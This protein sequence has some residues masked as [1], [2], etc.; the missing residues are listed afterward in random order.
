MLRGL[1][2]QIGLCRDAGVNL[3][4]TADVYSNGVS[5]EIVGEALGKD[6]DEVLVATKVRFPMGAGPN[7]AGLYAPSHREGGRGQPAPPAHRPYRPVPGARV[8]WPDPLEET[9]SAFDS[10]VR[11]GKVRYIGASNYSAW[12][13]MKAL[14]VSK[15]YGFARFVSQQIYYSLQAGCGIGIGA[16]LDRPGTRHPRGAR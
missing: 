11:S 12:H 16:S 2:R 10:L 5:E 3:I 14:A 1:A 9:L 15:R 13:L 7:D 4:D 6:R 8:G